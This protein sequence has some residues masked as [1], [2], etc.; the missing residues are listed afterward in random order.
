MHKIAAFLQNAKKYPRHLAM[1]GKMTCMMQI[2]FRHF[3]ACV[4]RRRGGGQIVDKRCL[5][6]GHVHAKEQRQQHG[7]DVCKRVARH[8]QHGRI[9][10][11][12]QQTPADERQIGRASCRERV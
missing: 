4:I 1:P 6:G 11:G 9:K 7:A 3:A 10:H 5:S 2:L 8:R 12:N